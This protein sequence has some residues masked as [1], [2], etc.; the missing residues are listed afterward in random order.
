M[1]FETKVSMIFVLHRSISWTCL[2][3]TWIMVSTLLGRNVYKPCSRL[4]KQNICYLPFTVIYYP[5]LLRKVQITCGTSTIQISHNI[6]TRLIPP[7]PRKIKKRGK[8][9]F[10]EEKSLDNKSP[11]IHCSLKCHCKFLFVICILSHLFGLPKY[12]MTR[13]NI[14]RY[15]TKRNV[16]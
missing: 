11:I 2:R 1:H 7:T 6:F 15:Y 3:T 10:W 14:Q 8:S 4:D 5:T 16:L 13:R 12:C 9:L